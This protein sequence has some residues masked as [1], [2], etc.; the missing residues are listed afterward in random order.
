MEIGGPNQSDVGCM[1]TWGLYLVR[2]HDL[3]DGAFWL[4]ENLGVVD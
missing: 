3:A 4:L 2:C 1:G